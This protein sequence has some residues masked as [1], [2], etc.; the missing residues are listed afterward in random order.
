MPI[1]RVLLRFFLL[2]LWIMAGAWCSPAWAGG[3]EYPALGQFDVDEGTLEVWF[4]PMVADLYP[5]MGEKE[6]RGHFTLFHMQVPEC[7]VFGCSWISKGK[8]H[9]FHLSMGAAGAEKALLPVSGRPAKAWRPGERHHLAFTW[10]DRDMSLFLDGQLSGSRRQ[11][12]P[13]SGKMAGQALVVG[14]GQ[15]RD[16]RVIVHAVRLS[17]VARNEALLAGARPESDIYTTLLDR[18][19]DPAHIGP[20]GRTAAQQ[21]SDPGATQGGTLKGS[22]RFV[23]EPAPGVALFK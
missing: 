11:S 4:T 15:F 19:D 5:Q 9:G 8:Q 23:T 18:F 12:V 2:V 22:W 6:Y 7:F 13:L 17:S 14:N 3:I 10:R 1:H 21:T 20:G 16:S